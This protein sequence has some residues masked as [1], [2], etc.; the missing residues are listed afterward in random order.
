[1]G[2]IQL[3]NSSLVFPGIE[4]GMNL[5]HSPNWPIFG[6]A[7]PFLEGIRMCTHDFDLIKH[8]N[9]KIVPRRIPLGWT[10]FVCLYAFATSH[11]SLKCQKRC[12]LLLKMDF[13]WHM[14]IWWL[15]TFEPVDLKKSYLPQ[16]EAFQTTV[17]KKE[18]KDVWR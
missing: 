9:P 7:R 5:I 3:W 4:M 2:I 17:F 13:F 15:V 16:K 12:N 14:E 1:M 10:L 11:R 18:L 6:L 8:I